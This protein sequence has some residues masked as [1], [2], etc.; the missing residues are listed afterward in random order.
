MVED[1]LSIACPLHNGNTT[2]TLLDDMRI[3]FHQKLV[4]VFLEER[5][6]IVERLH[7]SSRNNGEPTFIYYFGK[8][9]TFKAEDLYGYSFGIL[10][11]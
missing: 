6:E 1:N 11:L 10:P 2:L 3:F 9:S 5:L 4:F 7:G 8:L